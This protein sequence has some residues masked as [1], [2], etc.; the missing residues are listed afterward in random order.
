V[1][2]GPTDHTFEQ[3][4]THHTAL[5]V[6]VKLGNNAVE[7]SFWAPKVA[8]DHFRAPDVTK[9]FQNAVLRS[10]CRTS[11]GQLSYFIVFHALLSFVIEL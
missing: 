10:L 11:Q 9:L 6:V 8:S 2:C 7:W 5:H 3:A 4:M 1:I